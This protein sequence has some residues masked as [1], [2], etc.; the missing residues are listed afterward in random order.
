M[1]LKIL[2]DL[3]LDLIKKKIVIEEYNNTKDNILEII[4]RFNFVNREKLYSLAAEKYPE[5][6]IGKVE[7]FTTIPIDLFI[8]LS[9]IPLVETKHHL[10]ISTINTQ[11]KNIINEFKKYT[12]KE[13]V[14]V[15][16]NYKDVITA[17][18]ELK[19]SKTKDVKIT[20]DINLF[21][22]N[23][24]EK[25]IEERASDIHIE[26]LEKTFMVR[27][28]VDGILI[29]YKVYPDNIYD[30]LIA[31]IKDLSSMDVS[32][33]RLP[34]D[35]AFTMEIKKKRIDFRVATIP[36]MKGEKVTIRILNKDVV[37]KDI[38]ELGLS[39]LDEW[40]FLTN[41]NNGLILVCGATGSG[42]TTT[43]YTT[44]QQIDY[45]GR[46]V[47]TVEDPVEFVFPFR[48]QI[49]VNRRAGMDFSNILRALMRH[50]PDVCVIGEI[51]D[52]ETAENALR[53]ADTGH[54][55]YATLHTNDVPSS[56]IRLL[57]LGAELTYLKFLLRG[58]LVQKLARKICPNCRKE[59]GKIE[60]CHVCK[61]T[62]YYGRTP[63]VEF[64]KINSPKD[65][66]DLLNEKLKYY[67]FCED[68]RKKLKEGIID[69]EEVKRLGFEE[70][71]K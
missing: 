36:T 67:T 30:S 70:C 38:T 32:E 25:A 63:V 34:Q 69:I 13:I 37:L 8:N 6:L 45:L 28:R 66:E 24:L 62:G 47:Y 11:I 22:K 61:G 57:D 51:R 33:K 64:A 29:P 35:G 46:S 52:R 41:Y 54:L 12:D 58:I 48:W 21:I 53:L 9:T 50:D 43:L 1:S 19:V 15:N 18:N 2:D 39:V 44:M 14:I 68:V 60:H 23:L 17:L 55:V 31:R 4:E 49:Q 40:L 7:I 3:N 56:V 20:E 42:K 27:F 71:I 65:I 5:L 26:P 10:Y 59:K 16:S